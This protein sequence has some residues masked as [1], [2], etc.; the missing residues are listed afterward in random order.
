M[1]SVTHANTAVSLEEQARA[2][3]ELLGGGVELGILQH[4]PSDWFAE[5]PGQ[6]LDTDHIETLIAERNIARAEKNWSRADQI[7]EELEAIGV[8]IQD[9]LDGTEWRT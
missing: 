7:R 8:Q 6:T 3:S 4:S 9:S 2:K 5:H 1:E